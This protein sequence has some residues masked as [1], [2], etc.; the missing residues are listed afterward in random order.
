MP[1]NLSMILKQAME[2]KLQLAP[3]QSQV[4][5]SGERGQHIPWTITGLFQYGSIIVPAWINNQIQYKVWK[6][7]FEIPYPFPN[8]NGT[9]V[10]P[11]EPWTWAY[12]NLSILGL[13]LN[14]VSKRYRRIVNISLFSMG[15]AQANSATSVSRNY[16]DMQMYFNVIRKNQHVKS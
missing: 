12:D 11:W 9:T 8:Y 14:N 13:T 3:M 5:I 10:E 7:P 1:W 15:R 2:Y 16:K 4:N 6:F